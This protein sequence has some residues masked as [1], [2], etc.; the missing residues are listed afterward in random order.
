MPTPTTPGVLPLTESPNPQMDPEETLAR[1]SSSSDV[2]KQ[3]GGFCWREAGSRPPLSFPDGPVYVAPI[4]DTLPLSS[5]SEAKQALW[6][7]WQPLFSSCI[8]P[9]VLWDITWPMVH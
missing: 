4:D 1:V 9:G 8:L 6:L 5:I 3:F 7:P 2:D